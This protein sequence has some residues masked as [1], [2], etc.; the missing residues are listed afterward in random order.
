MTEVYNGY[1]EKFLTGK[2]LKDMF[3][4]TFYCGNRHHATVFDIPVK[5][6]LEFLNID[7]NTTYKIFYNNL[8]CKVMLPEKD[9]YINFFG[10]TTLENTIYKDRHLIAN[11]RYCPICNNKLILKQGKFG[12]FWSCSNYPECKGSK[13]VMILSELGHFGFKPCNIIE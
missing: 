1:L 11:N 8:F 9:K 2:E 3:Y 7:N 6:Y 4:N 10:Y 13:K 12:L 5:E